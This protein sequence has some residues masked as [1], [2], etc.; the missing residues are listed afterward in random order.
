MQSSACSKR[1]A[2]YDAEAAGERVLLH[3]VGAEKEFAKTVKNSKFG[4]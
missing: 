4:P 3:A 1:P 2:G